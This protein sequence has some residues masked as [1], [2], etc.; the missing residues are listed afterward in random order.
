MQK[1]KWSLYFDDG[2]SS[3]GSDDDMG[4]LV[5]LGNFNCIPDFWSCYRSAE[6]S[7]NRVCDS[8][9]HWALRLFKSQTRD[10]SKDGGRWVI[11]PSIES[12]KKT[13]ELWLGLVLAVVTD[14]LS[15]GDIVV[16]DLAPPPPPPPLPTNHNEP[17]LLPTHLDLLLFSCLSPA[18][19]CV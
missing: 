10:V 7:L 2:T 11:R 16:S 4:S 13:K 3:N 12:Q 15:H 1:H 14:R 18:T 17:S 6:D 9:G 8:R 5:P 19:V